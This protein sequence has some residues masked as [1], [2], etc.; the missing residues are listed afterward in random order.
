MVACASAV[1]GM[2]ILSFSFP[3]VKFFVIGPVSNA[4]FSSHRAQVHGRRGLGRKLHAW[5]TQHKH[6]VSP[7]SSTDIQAYDP[8]ICLHSWGFCQF[9]KVLLKLDRTQPSFP[10]PLY[11]KPYKNCFKTRWYGEVILVFHYSRDRDP[12][13]PVQA[14]RGTCIIELNKP[15]S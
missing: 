14:L 15:I 8:S 3:V 2:G 12:T 10:P 1:V 9:L 5:T 7:C 6:A 4:L 13:A 11:I